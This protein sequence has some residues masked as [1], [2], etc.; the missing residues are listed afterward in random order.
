MY[1]SHTRAADQRA[2]TAPRSAGDPG[3]PRSRIPATV[4]AL[5]TVSLVTDISA[6]MVTASMGMYLMYGLGV[7]YAALGAF[8]ALYTAAS[9]LLRLGG[10][11]VADRLGRPK[12]VATAGY[13]LSAVCK[14]GLPAV[15]ASLGAISAVVA[16]DRAGKGIRT[17]PRDALISA[18]TRPEDLGRSF[19]VH[20]AMDTCGAL[21]GPVVA[22]ALLWAVPGGYD[23][24]FFT[25]FC[26]A[27]AGV[28]VLVVFVREPGPAAPRRVPPRLRSGL[29]VLAAPALRRP[30]LATV[31]LGL[32]TA[33]DLFLFVAVQQRS[34]LPGHVL[35]LL[36]LATAACFMLVAVPL[37]RLADR[38]GRW[39]VF[40]GGH[41]ALLA[42]Y[43]VLLGPAGGWATAALALA[44]HGVFY[45]ATDG[46]LMAYAAAHVP[47]EVRATGLAVVQT[48]QA[49]ARAVGALALGLLAALWSLPAAF[50]VL[51]LGLA[52]ATLAAGTV[53]APRVVEGAER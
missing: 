52:L 30:I 12:A 32:A 36:P 28:V 46:V 1:L 44:L 2:P 18:A 49:L 26:L 17:A 14:L 9:A 53:L 51:G 4:L 27:M 7:G 42:A 38:V 35:P 39:T 22:F 48:A 10:G 40:V 37:G 15:G 50:L 24:V 3:G 19:G 13:G 23:V 20:R 21:L 8:D 29:A 41:V 45:A 43:A 11:L 16:A 31:L 5:G 33:G 25:S 47:A 34:G 6:E